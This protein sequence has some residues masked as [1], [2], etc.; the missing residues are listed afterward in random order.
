MRLIKKNP[1]RLRGTRVEINMLIEA[2]NKFF[3]LMDNRDLIKLMQTTQVE[4]WKTTPKFSTIIGLR[5]LPLCI[6]AVSPTLCINHADLFDSI[7]QCNA[8]NTCIF[9]K[10]PAEYEVNLLSST[11]RCY[12]SKW[13]FVKARGD[14]WR[15]MVRQAVVS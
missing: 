1:S 13:R 8:G 15:R 2:L 5:A 6:A 14:C 3:L 10:L 4:G 9:G 12:L 11:I 7:L